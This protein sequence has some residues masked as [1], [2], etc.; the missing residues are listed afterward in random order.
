MRL[1]AYS[2]KCDVNGALII[3]SQA[4]EI[5]SVWG[6]IDWGEGGMLSHKRRLENG[7]LRLRPEMLS[8]S[9]VLPL[10]LCHCMFEFY[11]E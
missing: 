7:V 8:F 6:L 5:T 4:R 2:L 11:H 1:G 9:C 3:G 10:A